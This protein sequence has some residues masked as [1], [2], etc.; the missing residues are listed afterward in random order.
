M[1]L[2]A[3]L[4]GFPKAEFLEKH[5]FRLPYS[6]S[7]AARALAAAADWPVVERI[8]GRSGV[9]SFLAKEGRRWEAGKTPTWPEALAQFG[10]GYTIVLRDAQKN[11]PG[12]DAL[13]KSFFDEFKAPVN[14]HVYCTPKERTGFGWHYD[15]EDVFI[16]QSAGVKEYR[17]RKNTVNP[18]PILETVPEDMRFEREVTPFFT[19]R[20]GPGDWLYIPPGWWHEARAA[21]DSIT[22]AVGLMSPAAIEVLDFLRKELANSVI[23]RQRLPT[24]AWGDDPIERYRALFTDLGKDLA[25]VLADE[26]TVRRFFKK[27]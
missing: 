27:D 7:G 21:E 4:E 8:L 20:L 10:Q 9:D 24:P 11:D 17:L 19:C 14:V 1:V 23:W 26:I 25:R 15:V 16:L 13:A 3:L 2:D 6:R 22:I 18:W 5:Y 12:L